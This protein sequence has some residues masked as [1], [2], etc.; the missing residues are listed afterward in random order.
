[1]T[2]RLTRY[3]GQLFFVWLDSLGDGLPIPDTRRTYRRAIYR[4]PLSFKPTCRESIR[5]ERAA[6]SAGALGAI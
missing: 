4:S 5:T 1:M 6:P 2:V 3:R